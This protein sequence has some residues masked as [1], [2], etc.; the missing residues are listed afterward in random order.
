M[1]PAPVVTRSPIASSCAGQRLSKNYGI[2]ESD[3]RRFRSDR[4]RLQ[5]AGDGR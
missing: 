1:S 4:R 3:T 2:L 5:M